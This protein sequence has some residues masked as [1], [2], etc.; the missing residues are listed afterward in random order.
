MKKFHLTKKD[1]SWKLASEDSS[2]AIKKFDN[3]TDGVKKSAEYVKE[4]GGG[5][6]LIHKENGRFQEERTYPKSIDPKKSKG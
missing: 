5:S 6:L 1:D 2:R 3:K 4:H